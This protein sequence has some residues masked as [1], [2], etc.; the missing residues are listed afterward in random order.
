MAD[1]QVDPAALC[2]LAPVVHRLVEEL[3][4]ARG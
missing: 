2:D 3:A 1:I 4:T